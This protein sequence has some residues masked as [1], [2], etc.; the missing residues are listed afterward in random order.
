MSFFHKVLNESKESGDI[1]SCSVPVP[2]SDN[3]VLR[4]DLQGSM[5]V[6]K[7]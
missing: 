1:K 7:S 6:K 5:T 4:G 2:D 3:E